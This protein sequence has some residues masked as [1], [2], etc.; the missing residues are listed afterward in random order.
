MSRHHREL[1]MATGGQTC[2]E[3]VDDRWETTGF[4]T[5]H[6]PTPGAVAHPCANLW[7]TTR[8]QVCRLTRLDAMFSTIHSTYYF[9]Y[10]CTNI[11]MKKR[12]T[13]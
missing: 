1:A 2:D 11:S 12:A 10:S 8:G 6:R 7:T 3:H 13:L 9:H 5:G 4:S